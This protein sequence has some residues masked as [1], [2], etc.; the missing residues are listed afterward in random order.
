M[1]RPIL[2]AVFTLSLLCALLVSPA[3]ARPEGV[4]TIAYGT[5]E[6][7][8]FDLHAADDAESSAAVPAVIFVHGGGWQRGDKAA[9]S[10][11]AKAA[12]VTSLGYAFISVNYRLLPE[13]DA[14]AQAQDVAAAIAYVMENAA[15]LGVDASRIVLSGHSAGAHLAGLVATDESLL[16]Q[17]GHSPA[18]LAG[19]ILL[20]GA[21]YDVEAQIAQADGRRADMYHAAFGTQ[22]DRWRELS[23]TAHVGGK[24][25]PVFLLLHVERAGAAAQA[26][27][28]GAMLAAEGRDAEVVGV[29]GRGLRGHRDISAR[30]GEA[31]YPATPIVTNWLARIFTV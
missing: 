1:F 9:A 29:A 16:A 20:D 15:A 30:L 22:P 26:K 11:R 27:A 5:H 31:D 6:L 4:R 18:S 19:V 13:S 14:E 25:A 17:H 2:I 7:Q 24:D 28:L 12:H 3:G 21:A 10:H 23:P 8:Q